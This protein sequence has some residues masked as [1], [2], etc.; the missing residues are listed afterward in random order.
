MTYTSKFIGDNTYE[1]ESEFNEELVKFRV[2]VA[3]DDSE[4]EGLVNFYL[5]SL[6]NPKQ[7]IQQENSQTNLESLVQEQQ[8]II[9][10]LQ[11]D[12]AA[13]KGTA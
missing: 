13:L 2:V 3:N 9:T 8:A 1:I 11:A 10:Q 7:V 6:A 5:D 4:V 12:V